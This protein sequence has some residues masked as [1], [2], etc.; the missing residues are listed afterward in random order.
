[1]PLPSWKKSLSPFSHYKIKYYVLSIIW[2]INWCDQRSL[3]DQ[4][5]IPSSA[6]VLSCFICVWLFATLW[7]VG[8][9]VHGTPQARIVE[10][11][12]VASSR[13]S[14]R[15]Q[16]GTCVA[17]VSCALAGGFFTTHT[18]WEG[19]QYCRGYRTIMR[20]VPKWMTFRKQWLWS[21]KHFFNINSNTMRYFLW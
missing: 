6:W 5:L 18:T 10:W 4:P 13:G 11:I 16:D 9:S 15:P 1:M 21:L 20:L 19:R 17:Y 8:S 12:A 2:N 3:L 7:T 14:S